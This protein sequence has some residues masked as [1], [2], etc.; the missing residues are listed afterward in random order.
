MDK[1]VVVI[2]TIGTIAMRTQ[3]VTV[4]VMILL[5]AAAD[6]ALIENTT[7][8]ALVIPSTLL[9]MAIDLSMILAGRVVMI[10][11]QID[12][13]SILVVVLEVKTIPIL[14]VE[15]ITLRAL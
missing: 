3:I 1:A 14:V 12:T 15:M 5:L 9:A 6:K 13:V 8:E 2:M 7:A 11:H 4:T 10:D